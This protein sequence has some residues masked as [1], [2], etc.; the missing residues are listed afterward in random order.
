MAILNFFKSIRPSQ[1]APPVKLILHFTFYILHFTFYIL[2]FTSNFKALKTILAT[3]QLM[4]FF[5]VAAFNKAQHI[6]IPS[7]PRKWFGSADCD[8]KYIL[9]TVHTDPN[10]FR[11]KYC[12]KMGA[13]TRKTFRERREHAQIKSSHS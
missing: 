2:H 5:K 8:T 7:V 12:I 9:S 3:K 11:G 13:I 10:P 6:C 4:L 1:S